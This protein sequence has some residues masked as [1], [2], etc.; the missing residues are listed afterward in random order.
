MHLL[1]APLE[2][3]VLFDVLAELCQS[4]GSDAT[5]L[6]PCKHRLQQIRSVHG[7][8]GAPSP[9]HEVHFIDKQAH[10]PRSLL[11]LCQHCLEALFKLPPVLCTR[12]Q[13]AHVEADQAALRE[14]LWNVPLGDALRQ[15]FRDRSLADPWLPHQHRVVLGPPREYSD[16]SADLVVAA[17]HRVEGGGG[18]SEVCAVLQQCLERCV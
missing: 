5:Q 16:D 14:A 2:R 15:A 3:R 18:G 11:G 4:G 10:L 7:A 12:H 8:V 9:Q 17:D 13:R 6:A 1:E